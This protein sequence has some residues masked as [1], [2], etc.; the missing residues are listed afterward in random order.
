[1]TVGAVL[2]SFDGLIAEDY[3]SQPPPPRPC[4]STFHSFPPFH[5][6]RI[7]RK[8]PFTGQESLIDI[9]SFRKYCRMPKSYLNTKQNSIAV[10]SRA[11]TSSS[12]RYR[13]NTLYAYIGQ[14]QS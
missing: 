12:F 9:D 4:L 1:M 5:Q 6:C 7:G 13:L 11:H 2:L 3:L 14:R 10:G 8:Q